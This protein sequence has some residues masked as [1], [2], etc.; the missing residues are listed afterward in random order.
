MA[1]SLI[2]EQFLP[3]R[4]N[5]LAAEF[6]ARLH[7]IYGGRFGIDI[8]EWRVIATLGEQEPVTAQQI[9]RS[10]RTHKS[11][12]SRAVAKLVAMGWIERVPA[13]ADKRNLQIRFTEK[14]RAAFDEIVPLVL[15]V[16]RETLDQLGSEADSVFE[17][18][19]A[20]ERALELR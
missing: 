9:V 7:H 8:P 20:L 2:L 14:G 19:D 5:R 12:I 18:I 11:T 13:S 6:S 4:L 17:R 15:A 10:T 3:Y 1:R 16:E